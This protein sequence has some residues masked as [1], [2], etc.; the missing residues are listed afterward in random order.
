[1]H[2]NGHVYCIYC[3]RLYR[4]WNGDLLN[5]TSTTVPFG[6]LNSNIVQAN[7]LDRNFGVLYTLNLFAKYS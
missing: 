4:F 3:N 7:G 2:R 5:V 6:S 1:M